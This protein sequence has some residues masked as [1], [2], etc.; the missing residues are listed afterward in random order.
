[1]VELADTQ[2]LKSCGSNT[3]SVRVRFGAFSLRLQT[4]WNKHSKSN[5]KGMHSSKWKDKWGLMRTDR[6]DVRVWMFDKSIGVMVAH[7]RRSGKSRFKSLVLDIGV[8]P[9]G[10]AYDFDSYIRRFKSCYP[11]SKKYFKIFQKSIDI[12]YEVCYNWLVNKTETR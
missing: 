3:V 4:W 5:I 12:K 11:C 2:D 10:K 6:T 1:M 9:S 7:P 8:S